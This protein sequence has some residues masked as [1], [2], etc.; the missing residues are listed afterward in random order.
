[1]NISA[2]AS[3][4]TGDDVPYWRTLKSDSE[5]NPGFPNAPEEQIAL[6]ESE[7]FEIVQKGRK[8]IRYFV[9]DYENYLVSEI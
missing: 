8:K 2:H 4:E 3:V 1:V 9:K 5:L 6:L 7:G